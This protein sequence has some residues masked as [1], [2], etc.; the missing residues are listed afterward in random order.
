MSTPVAGDPLVDA[1]IL[2]TAK[3]LQDTFIVFNALMER[4]KNIGFDTMKELIPLVN[5]IED[6]A[7]QMR[8]DT[9]DQRFVLLR[10]SDGGLMK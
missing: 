9:D 1:E 3:S 10:Q 2:A 4:K 7:Q 5:V 6:S 8:R